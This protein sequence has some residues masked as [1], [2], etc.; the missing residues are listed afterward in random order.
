MA[1]DD[2]VTNTVTVITVVTSIKHLGY[3]RLIPERSHLS[4]LQSDQLAVFELS[5]AEV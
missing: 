2:T 1:L 4:H 5:F 3:S